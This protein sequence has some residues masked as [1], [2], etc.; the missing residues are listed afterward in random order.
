MGATSLVNVTV[1]ESAA[2]AGSDDTRRALNASAAE[3]R[4][5]RGSFSNDFPMQAAI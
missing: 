2:A 5:I 1:F 4:N 3:T